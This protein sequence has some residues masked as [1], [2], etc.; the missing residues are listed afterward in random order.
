MLNRR[1]A[2]V[3]LGL[4]VAAGSVAHGQPTQQVIAEGDWSAPVADHGGRTIRGRLI[5]AQEIRGQEDRDVGV[6][7][8]LQET[9]DAVGGEPLWLYCEL[10]RSDFRP[11]YRPGLHCELRDATGKPVP[12]E[13]F[14]FS[15]AVPRSEWVVLPPDATLRLRASP[16]GLRRPGALVLAP[17]VAHLWVIRLTAEQ[18][19]TLGGTFTI[20]PADDWQPPA[21]GW[22]W[23]GTLELPAVPIRAQ[24]R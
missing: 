18:D 7:L 19:Y 6:Y 9:A 11:E 8:E 23:R 16:W 15:G 1:F 22:V 13:P 2:A 5:L 24:I 20:E 14:A 12:S 17:D 3:F 4:A 10:G 21:A